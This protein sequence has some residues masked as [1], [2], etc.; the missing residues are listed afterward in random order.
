MLV[1]VQ[2]EEQIPVDRPIHACSEG[3]IVVGAEADIQNR[4][5]MLICGYEAGSLWT[6][7]K[8]IMV[9]LVVPGRDEELRA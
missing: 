6:I 5:A 9:Y 7:C 4:S 8:V 3:L 2:L 1:F